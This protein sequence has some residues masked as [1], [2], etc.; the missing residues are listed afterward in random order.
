MLPVSPITRRRFLALSTSALAAA[1]AA[2]TESGDRGQ[3]TFTPAPRSPSPAI[4]PSTAASATPLASP[5]PGT[6]LETKIGQMLMVGFRGLTIDAADPFGAAVAA[7]RVGHVVLFDTD[8]PSGSDVR[9][10][11]DPA[12]LAALTAQLQTLGPELMLIAT[13]EEGGKVARLDERHG[14]PATVSEEYLGHQDDEALTARYAGTMATALANSG[15][16]LN[17]APVVDL[18]VNPNNPVIGS[19]GRSFSA[20]PDVVTRQALAFIDAHHKQTVLCTL[21]HF[22]G[23]GSST[24]DSHVGFVD[25]TTTWSRTELEP[26]RRI[27][28][29]GQA[30]VVMTAHI[31]NAT[32]DADYPATLSKKTIDGMLRGELGYQG[33]VVTDDMQMGA[34]REQY[35][36][37][38]ALELA[39]N[40][41][42]DIVSI[43]NNTI[44][45]A[46]VH[47]R[48]FSAVAQAVQAG[49]I[50]PARIDEAYGRITALKR[51]LVDA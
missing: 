23:H 51:R 30:D 2:C 7:G 16:N 5:T 50:D 12:Q 13:D 48:A 44:Y 43:A 18:N 37:E 20:D 33:V 28:A 3:S 40:A 25:V 27:I 19:L 49:R 11:Q 35:G 14:F 24:A 34:I 32:V 36:F 46:D 47:E 21:K 45:E 38:Q 10:I 42:A 41:G 26:F 22:P 15:I 9:N 29:A 4:T 6:T 31:F 39:V 8:V 17:L 1:V